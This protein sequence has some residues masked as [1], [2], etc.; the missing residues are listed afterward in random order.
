MV[1]LDDM[2]FKFYKQGVIE[3]DQMMTYAK[4][5]GFLQRKVEEDRGGQAAG[6]AGGSPPNKK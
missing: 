5:Q 4:D 3:F 1:L 2:L 6:A